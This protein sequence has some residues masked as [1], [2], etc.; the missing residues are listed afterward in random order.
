MFSAKRI[1]RGF[2]GAAI[3]VLLV[4][5]C[6][7]FSVKTAQPAPHARSAAET[8]A[9]QVSS[10]PELT[11]FPEL[12]AAHITSLFISTPQRSF[13]FQL[14]PHGAVSVNGQQAD[15][16][17]FSVL[18]DQISDLPVQQNVAFAPQAQDLL[19]TLVISTDTHQRTARF[20]ED[21][22]RGET[23]RIV[24]DTDHAP[25]YLKTNAWRVGTLMM[26]CEGTRIL[27]AHGNEQTAI[28]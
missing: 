14:S 12:N 21:G 13:R 11:L 22:G 28:Q 25:E 19:L 5:L 24:L 26:A 1:I 27:D 18:L 6:I 16:D 4:W 9:D 23:A 3:I 17:I 2:Y 8:Q 20:Y 7:L 15:G 10:V